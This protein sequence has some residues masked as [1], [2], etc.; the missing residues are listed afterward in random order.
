MKPS[1]RTSVPALAALS[2]LLLA[3]CS[4]SYLV[5]IK[6]PPDAEIYVNGRPAGRG[7]E[8]RVKFDFSACERVYLQVRCK[9]YVP[10]LET[11]TTETVPAD[12]HK[13]VH[14]TPTR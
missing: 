5:T 8:A 1:R 13:E 2:G 10:S 11:F 4:S 6:T 14:L 7:P 12:L 3:G 9:G